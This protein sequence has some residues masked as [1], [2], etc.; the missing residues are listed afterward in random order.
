MAFSFFSQDDHLRNIIGRFVFASTVLSCYTG[1]GEVRTFGISAPP[2]FSSLLNAAHSRPYS[3][4]ATKSSD[5]TPTTRFSHLGH[6]S[7]CYEA[8]GSP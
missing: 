2:L 4:I 8:R 3:Q 1:K 5:P 6:Q 7:A